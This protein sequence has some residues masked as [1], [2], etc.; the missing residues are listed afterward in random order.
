LDQSQGDISWP[1]LP[2]I[3]F[4]RGATMTK[5]VGGGLDPGKIGPGE[6]RRPEGGPNGSG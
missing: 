1:H 2:V 3:G 4:S 5:V 6:R